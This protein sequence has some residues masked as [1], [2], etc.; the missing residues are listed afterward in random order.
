MTRMTGPDCVVMCNFI[1]TYIH[2]CQKKYYY[3]ISSITVLLFCMLNNTIITKYSFL[4]LLR[5]GISYPKKNSL[6]SSKKYCQ[7][8]GTMFLVVS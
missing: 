1:N 4:L 3:M 5:T 8:A 6:A 2:T 7:V